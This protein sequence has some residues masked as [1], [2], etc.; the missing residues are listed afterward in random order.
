MAIMMLQ[1]HS[2]NNKIEVMLFKVLKIVWVKYE[3]KIRNQSTL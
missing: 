2:K 3:K 1:C